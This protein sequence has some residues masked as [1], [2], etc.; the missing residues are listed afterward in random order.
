M[1]ELLKLLE[2]NNRISFKMTVPAVTELRQ[3]EMHVFDLME[4]I[5]E[6]ELKIQELTD[7]QRALKL[8]R[9]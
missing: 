2:E 6:K 4:R 9:D 7:I 1:N 3:L 5:T 8:N